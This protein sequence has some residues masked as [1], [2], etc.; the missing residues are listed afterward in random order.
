MLKKYLL[1]NI[2]TIFFPIFFVLFSITSII[3]LVKI[4]A[5]TSIIEINI[6][7]LLLLYSYTIPR[8]L[9]Y[10]LPISYFI[11]LAI[12]L[13]RL[14]A[15][16]E[17]LVISSFGY[18]PLDTLKNVLVPTF[19]LSITLIVI[20]LALMPKVTYLNNK[21][22]QNKKTQAKFNIKAS[23]YGQEFGNWLIYIDSDNGKNKFNNIKLLKKENN[24][25]KFIIAKK[26]EVT[27]EDSNLNLMLHFGKAFVFSDALEQIDF[28][29]MTITDKSDLSSF[30]NFTN[31]FTS[32]LLKFSK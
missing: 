19:L 26:A 22:I 16:Y 3:F 30:K 13:S 28:E 10:T 29:T 25:D 20:S 17:L 11:G 1:S 12:T 15:E 18:R 4:A 32:F 27:N 21:F 7:E 9:F 2:S 6:F 31:N 23:Q 8:I 14:S 5:L 24:L